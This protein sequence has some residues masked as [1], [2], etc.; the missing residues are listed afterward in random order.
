MFTPIRSGQAGPAGQTDPSSQ[1]APTRSGPSRTSPSLQRPEGAPPSLSQAGASYP[2][3]PYK[4]IG[5]LRQAGMGKD[6]SDAMAGMPVPY[7]NAAERQ[8]H[9]VTVGAD[10][11]LYQQQQGQPARM[12]TAGAQNPPGANIYAMNKHGN[13]YSAPSTEV[14]H[15]SAF[16]AGNPGAAF[17]TMQVADGQLGM[18]T[19]SS[20]HYAPPRDYTKQFVQEMKARNA[21]LSQMDT[22]F[23]GLEKKEIK[24]KGL[25]FERLYP[26]GPK[27]KRY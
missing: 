25:E 23:Q 14:E 5:M 17:G 7:L 9:E 22:R 18:V 20:G 13:I 10:G 3:K 27:T 15:H 6:L 16:F 12:D 1:Q 11:R 19:D 8:R 2:R 26:S 4:E 21:D 24:K